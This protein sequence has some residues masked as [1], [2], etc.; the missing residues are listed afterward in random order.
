MLSPLE[1]LY[2]LASAKSSRDKE[3]EA[4]AITTYGMVG[5]KLVAVGPGEDAP[6]GFKALAGVTGSGAS[7]SIPQ[8]KTP[9]PITQN[10]DYF[11]KDVDSVPG[12]GN[13]TSSGGGN[14]YSAWQQI[15]MREGLEGE[16]LTTAM[17]NLHMIGTATYKN[18]IRQ[19]VTL[20]KELY[21]QEDNSVKTAV[22]TGSSTLGYQFNKKFYADSAEDLAKLEED[23]NTLR[24][25]DSDAIINIVPS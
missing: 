1:I 18:G 22:A 23:V 16:G 21:E 10:V 25:E 14:S 7:I 20:N 2:A 12:S 19:S 17:N 15:F 3:K 6:E 9:D 5:E 13:F 11:A 4:A 24:D 8:P